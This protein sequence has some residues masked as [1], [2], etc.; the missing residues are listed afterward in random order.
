MQIWSENGINGAWRTI[1]RLWSLAVE[2][3]EKVAP[4]GEEPPAV[5]DEGNREI[6]RRTHQAIGRVGDAIEG[7][8]QFNTAIARCN[9]LLGLLRARF[10]EVH[11]AVLRETLE[12]ILKVLS[13][14]TPHLCEEL[15]ER[16]GHS[17]SIFTCGWPEAD[18]E[19][20]AEEEIEIPVQVNGKV[21]ARLHVSP[22]IS[23]AELEQAALN[24]ERV[25]RYVAGKQVVK[26]IVVPGRLVNVAL[27]G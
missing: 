17:A 23:R 22:D 18:P 9:E 3:L 2:G 25:Q 6:R 5:L 12:T 16:L 11:P 7:G 20:A 14:I 27:K 24:D 1:N 4:L 8:L 13:P 19:V 15:W 26:V 10:G 21:R